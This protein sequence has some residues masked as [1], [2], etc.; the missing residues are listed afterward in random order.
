MVQKTFRGPR[1]SRAAAKPFCSTRTTAGMMFSDQSQVA[2]VAIEV[3][4]PADTTMAQLHVATRSDG[5][6]RQSALTQNCRP[7]AN[8]STVATVDMASLPPG[9]YRLQGYLEGPGGKRIFTPSSYT[10]VKV[11]GAT[12]ASMKA[13]IDA[14]NIIHMGG[15]PRFVIGLYDTTGFALSRRVTTLRD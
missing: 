2:R 9:R 10:I 15:R 4:P 13:W 1:E 12:H 5:R 8:G 3:H 7:P 11:S 6:G 14:D